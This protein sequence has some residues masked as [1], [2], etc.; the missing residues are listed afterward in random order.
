LAHCA[1][2][3]G[4]SPRRSGGSSGGGT[5]HT[6]ACVN[7]ERHM[8]EELEFDV[9]FGIART[10]GLGRTPRGHAHRAVRNAAGA[11]DLS[12]VVASAAGR[13]LTADERAEPHVAMPPR[14]A[15]SEPKYTP[16]A[17]QLSVDPGKARGYPSAVVGPH[18]ERERREVR[19][20]AL[21]ALSPDQSERGLAMEKIF[22]NVLRASAG[23]NNR[24]I[25]KRKLE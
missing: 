16:P 25:F 2:I 1:P 11:E 20:R 24:E 10:F 22:Q 21:A 19:A 7:A 17:S 13:V 5:V 18:A 6:W 8:L 9:L 3:S 23:T 15:R 12:N 14:S 4:T